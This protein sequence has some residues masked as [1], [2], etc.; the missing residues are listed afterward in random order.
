M[1]LGDIP[2]RNSLR[3]PYK[4]ALVFGD[5]SLSWCQVNERVNALVY[6]LRDRGIQKG[7]RVG[8]LME[9]C[10]QYLE[11]YWA[12]AKSG[13][14][15]VPLNY[16]LSIYETKELLCSAEPKALI[17]GEEYVGKMQDLRDSGIDIGC[18]IGVGNVSDQIENYESLLLKY[19]TN[20]PES[21][22][23]EDDIFA[24]FYTSGTTG[25]PKGAMV[26]NRNLEANCFNQFYADKSSYDDINLVATPLYHMG[27]VFMATT[28]SYLGCTNNILKHFT[29]RGALE[30]IQREKVTVC[31]LIPTMINMLLNHPNIN[32]YD[33]TSLR[34]IFYGGGPMH[35]QVLKKAIDLI[36]CGFTQGYGLT[37]T[38]EA[39]F[40]VSEDHVLEGTEK[41]Q[42]R[43]YSAGREALSA[44]VRTIDYNGNDLPPGEVGE[45]L[46]KSRSVIR[47]YWKMPELT[48]E[49]I[50]NDWF[51]TG[52]LGYL[53]EERYLF[54]VDRKK[55]MII[56]GGVNIYPKEIEEVIYTNPAVLEAAVIGIPDEL[57][58]E[59]V[60][61][62]VVL[63][64]GCRISEDELIEYCKQHMASYKN[65]NM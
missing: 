53:D 13:A 22:G 11:T 10:H 52:D 46:I 30:I 51:Y 7:D 48:A 44:E 18:V 23:K 41:Q 59:S 4:K 60:K 62:L 35:V 50:K 26:S 42:Q 58:G 16:R 54:I 5:V 40:L 33:L 6:A 56:S 63:K 36:G 3:F 31:L 21:I 37:E 1:N 65:Q 19:P 27:A 57:W 25:L 14:I 38:L 34:L 45:V 17:V 15:A 61:A 55:D 24:I 12:L 49:T 32:N 64:D 43:L 8:I 29:P 9:N 39:T 20:E 47:G 2:R 28:Y